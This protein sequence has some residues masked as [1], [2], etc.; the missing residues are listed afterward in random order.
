VDSPQTQQ[1]GLRGF[2]F[3]W[4]SRHASGVTMP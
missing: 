1:Q 4:R 3:G 2:F